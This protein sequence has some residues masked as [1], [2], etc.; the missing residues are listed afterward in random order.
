MVSYQEPNLLDSD[1]PVTT[2]SRREA[3]KAETTNDDDM[4]FNLLDGTPIGSGG[5]S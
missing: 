3:P 1:T 5:N 4:N 2:K